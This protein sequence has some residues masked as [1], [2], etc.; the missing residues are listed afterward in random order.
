MSKVISKD[1]IDDPHDLEMSLYVNNMI[2]QSD[3]TGKMHFKIYEQL[4][5]ISRYV[6]LYPGDIILTGTPKGVGTL[7]IRDN[8]YANMKNKN[9]IIVEMNFKIEEKLFKPN[10]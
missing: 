3:N 10:F 4:E 2:R 1:L 5:Y 9:C 7:N 6:T 8:I